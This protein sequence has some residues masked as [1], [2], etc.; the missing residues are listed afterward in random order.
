[1]K[2]RFNASGYYSADF[3]TMFPECKEEE[4]EFKKL[5]DAHFYHTYFTEHSRIKQWLH[6]FAYRPAMRAGAALSGLFQKIPA[7]FPASQVTSTFR[8]LSI[9]GS[10]SARYARR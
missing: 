2:I 1:M 9:P 3:T 10:L 5:R 7:L 8:V 6:R 4:N